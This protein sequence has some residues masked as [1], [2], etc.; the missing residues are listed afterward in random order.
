MLRVNLLPEEERTSGGRGFSLS[1]EA[2]PR[3]GKLM[4]AASDPWGLALVAAAVAVLLGV[5]TSWYFQA[6]HADR[7]EEQLSA[8]VEDSARLA[9][10]RALDDSLRTRNEEIERR[11][12]LVSRL[13][14]DRF[15]WARALHALAAALPEPAWL[16]LVEAEDPL[17]GLRLRVE[18]A[19]TDPLSVTRYVR[20]LDDFRWMN[21]ATLEGT[22]RVTE[23]SGDAQSF[24]LT[25]EYRPPGGAA[26]GG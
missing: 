25:V 21:D 13:D 10:L 14:R 11:L 22:A 20:S 18:G 4:E 26:G 8:A 24:T 5:G 6:R 23:G 7:L 16:T 12:G 17:P 15:A 2:L 1:L 19:A 9:E 3:P